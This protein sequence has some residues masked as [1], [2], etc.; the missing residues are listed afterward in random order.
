MITTWTESQPSTVI[1]RRV[2]QP[3][4]TTSSPD[5]ERSQHSNNSF[6]SVVLFRAF[7]LWRR[8][9]P[10]LGHFD[11]SSRIHETKPKSMT[12]KRIIMKVHAWWFSF[13]KIPSLSYSHLNNISTFSFAV[14]GFLENWC[15]IFIWLFKV[16]K[17][18]SIDFQ[19]F[20][21]FFTLK[22]WK[23]NIEAC[24]IGFPVIGNKICFLGAP[25]RNQIVNVILYGRNI[26]FNI[27]KCWKVTGFVSELASYY[28]GRWGNLKVAKFCFV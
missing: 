5:W 26:R 3:A 9:F 1:L 8:Q 11:H 17:T 18:W 12:E 23:P 28:W 22:F 7:L 13:C 21:I 24:S 19:V 14:F 6:T 20:N 25:V 2:C 15:L 27:K 10:F 4:R 16:L